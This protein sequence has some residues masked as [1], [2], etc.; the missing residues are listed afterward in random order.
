MVFAGGFVGYLLGIILNAVTST[1]HLRYTGALC[2]CCASWISALGTWLLSD[3]CDDAP[4]AEPG[5]LEDLTNWKLYSQRLIGHG[6]ARSKLATEDSD[7][8]SRLLAESGGVKISHNDGTA[9]STGIDRVLT[10]TSPNATHVVTGTLS[11]G[12]DILPETIKQWEAGYSEIIVVRRGIFAK[13]GLGDR[14]AVGVFED[15]HLKVFLGIPAL[16]GQGDDFAISEER[17]LIEV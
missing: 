17:S 15:G 14:F 8:I 11:N 5:A 10:R 9:I 16:Q 12:R 6:S 2:L 4:L 7:V 1:V 13:L 3:F